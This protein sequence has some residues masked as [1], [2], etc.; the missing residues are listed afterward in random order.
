MRPMSGGGGGGRWE[1]R[2]WL[3]PIPPPGPVAFVCEWPALQIPL[4]RTTLDAE[5]IRDAARR[6]V[7][8]WRAPEH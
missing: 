5:V 1:H 3:W 6:A 4:T 7:V 2:N 8:L